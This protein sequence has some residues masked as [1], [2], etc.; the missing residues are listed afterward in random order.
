VL[1]PA[2]NHAINN[3]YLSGPMDDLMLTPRGVEEA[4]KVR[5]AWRRWI[6]GRLAPLGADDPTTLDAALDHLARVT[7]A[8]PEL[9]PAGN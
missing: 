6:V 9:V 7:F 3:G 2:F 8:E 4:D 1:L 5:G